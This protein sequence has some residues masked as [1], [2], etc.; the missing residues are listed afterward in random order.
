MEAIPADFDFFAPEAIADPYSY[1][2][3]MRQDDPVHWH[4]PFGGWVI[5]RYDDVGWVTGNHDLFSTAYYTHDRRPPYPPIDDSD[6]YLY[7][8]VRKRFE[9]MFVHHD[10]PEH[11]AMRSI[12]HGYFTPKS[13]ATWRP[14]VRR[15]IDQLLDEAEAKGWV[16]LRADLALPL[17]VVVIAEMLNIPPQDRPYVTELGHKLLNNQLPE[18]DRMRHFTD[19]VREFHDYAASLVEERRSNPKDDLISLLVTGEEQGVLNRDQVL[20]NVQLL[21]SAGHETIANLLCNGTLAF[22]R[23]PEQWELLRQ[24]PEGMAV[25]ATEE[26]LRYDPPLKGLQRLVIQDVEV[27]G[28]LL[29]RFDRIMYVIASANRDPQAFAEPN[30]FDITL[31][32]KPHFAFAS[33]IHHCIGATLARVE[34]QE[35]F[36]ALAE[37]HRDLHLETETVEYRPTWPSRQLESL[38]MH[39]N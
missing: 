18:G 24:N 21:F 5:T 20:A 34:G 35:F 16:D 37:R 36:K 17:P 15:V 30:K 27:R 3:R 2:G 10:R 1:F 13:I 6:L 22:I 12:L 26:C 33:G 23:H 25:R 28:R 32:R 31:H 4:E 11:S 38:R 14:F 29:R 8:Y 9:N 39:W 19:A 7:E